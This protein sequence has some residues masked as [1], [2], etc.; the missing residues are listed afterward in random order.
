MR[1]R[2]AV[3]LGGAEGGRA[4]LVVVL[5]VEK[6]AALSA[7]SPLVSFAQPVCRQPLTTAPTTGNKGDPWETGGAFMVGCVAFAGR[8]VSADVAASGPGV[9]VMQPGGWE[10][11]P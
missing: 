10:I 5:L 6:E 3:V 7:P 2:C 8:L 9:M 11:A 1:C 4:E